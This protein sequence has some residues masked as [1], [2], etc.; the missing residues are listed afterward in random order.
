METRVKVKYG[1]QSLLDEL[2]RFSKTSGF[3]YS[4]D[5][6]NNYVEIV[7]HNN[8]WRIRLQPHTILIITDEDYLV[9]GRTTMLLNGE[10]EVEMLCNTYRCYH[11]DDIVR[12]IIFAILLY[13]SAVPEW[14]YNWISE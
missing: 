10:K 13:Q 14:I 9:I 12:Q 1:L 8:K 6:K 4:V 2:G 3:H 5:V 7:H 11:R